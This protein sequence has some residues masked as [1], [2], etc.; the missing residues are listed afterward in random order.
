M[1]PV[2]YTH[3]LDSDA[4]ESSLFQRLASHVLFADASMRPSSAAIRSGAGAPA[5][6]WALGISG[7]IPIVLLLIEAIEDIAI[8]RELLRAHEYWRMKQLAVDLVILNERPASYINDLQNALEMQLRMSQARAPLGAHD[9]RGAVFLLCSDRISV[10]T[11]ALLSS[12]AR[13]VLVG[14]R[15]SLAEQLDR[16]RAPVAAASRAP[17]PPARMGTAV[18]TCNSQGL[19]YFNGLGGFA[20]DGREYVTLLGTGQ[21]TPAPWLKMCIRDRH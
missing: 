19:E 7:D 6:L 13:V 10:Q 2:S 14:Q 1:P 16:A 17:S 21:S 18:A 4:A 5:G 15:G 3:L 8:A 9:A 20:Q 11:R 12:V